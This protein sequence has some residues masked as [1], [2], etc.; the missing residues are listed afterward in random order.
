MTG[1][2]RTILPLMLAC[3][4][5]VLVYRSLLDDSI[6]TLKFTR[7]G[8]RLGVGRES[9]I[10]RSYQVQDVMEYNPVTIPIQFSYDKIL[11]LFLT[12]P[13]SHYYVVDQN[14]RLEGRITIH[15]V[16]GILHEESLG[17]VLTHA[18]APSTWPSSWM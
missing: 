12:N 3:I 7:E 2:Y 15:D 1:E 9:A 16:K 8:L 4:A 11:R 6:F 10:L 18:L 17:K 14:D 5:A 13:D